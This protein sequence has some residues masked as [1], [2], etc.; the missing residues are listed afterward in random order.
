MSGVSI[1][2]SRRLLVTA[3]LTGVVSFGVVVATP[4]ST[5]TSTSPGYESSFGSRAYSQTGANG[6]GLRSKFA[7]TDALGSRSKLTMTNANGI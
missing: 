4:T 5:S 3:A 2:C 7:T 6:I 1:A